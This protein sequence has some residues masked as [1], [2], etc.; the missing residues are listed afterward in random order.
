M[1]TLQMDIL[2]AHNDDIKPMPE[3]QEEVLFDNVPV[4]SWAREDAVKR[5]DAERRRIIA[6]NLLH[7][8]PT[9]DTME[10]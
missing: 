5:A 6:E 2:Y 8:S 7:V 3:E 10:G 4:K 1:S 9:C